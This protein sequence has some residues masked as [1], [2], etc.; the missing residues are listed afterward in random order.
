MHLKKINCCFNSLIF[1][2]LSLY[3]NQALSEA[4]TQNRIL[5][6]TNID[7]ITS[8]KEADLVLFFPAY[9]C[10]SNYLLAGYKDGGLALSPES[11]GYVKN[12]YRADIIFASVDTKFASLNDVLNVL[13]DV[14]RLI[15]IYNIK[16]IYLIGGSLGSSTALNIASLADENIKQKIAGVLVYLPITDFEYTMKNTPNANLKTMLYND[17]IYRD[18]DGTLPKKSSP[19]TYVNDLSQ[20]A[21][22]ILIAGTRDSTVPKE[23]VDKYY[24]KAKSQGK[25]IYI[26][27]VNA[28][29]VTSEIENIYKKLVNELLR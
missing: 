27:K 8:K 2:I 3:P 5:I 13:K 18:S 20:K 11:K 15:N 12:N 10:S 6:Y 24:E 26:Y 16:H 17:F 19:I 14:K 4:G 22:I 25:N 7:N 1:L 28:D 9:H 21:K 23:Q 29:H